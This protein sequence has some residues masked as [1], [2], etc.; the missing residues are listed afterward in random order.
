MNTQHSSLQKLASQRPLLGFLQTQPSLQFAELAAISGY[1]FIMLDCEHGLISE[2]DVLQIAQVLGSTPVLTLVRIQGHDMR[3]IGR[4]LDM[5]VDGIIV[6]DVTTAEQATAL[7]RAM[8]Y[9][10]KGDRGFGAAAHRVTQYGIDT[11]AHIQSCRA[12]CALIVIIESAAG[13]QNIED[14]LCTI[15]I[16]GALLGPSDLS[17]SLGGIG[18]FTAPAYTN[19][20]DRFERIASR[21][22][23][24][25]GTGPHP[26]RSLEEL[27]A[28]GH[29]LI[30]LSTDMPLVREAMCAHVSRA[31]ALF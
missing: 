15:G 28:H 14:I 12:G 23:K 9:P 11:A 1:D 3:A 4:F 16:D 10:P 27:L 25:F 21:E 24:I 6:P 8:E 26:G 13:V 5:G 22:R 7:V 29:R 30:I 31:K 17:G 19:A 2:T 20:V 18:D